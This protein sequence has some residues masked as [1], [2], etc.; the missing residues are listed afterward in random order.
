MNISRWSRVA[1]TAGAA[2][3]GFGL[4]LA[5]AHAPPMRARVLAWALGA[6]E[7]YGIQGRAARL[8]YNLLTLDVRIHDLALAAPGRLSEPFFVA[9]YIEAD[10]GWPTIWGRWSAQA[11]EIRHPR[12]VYRAGLCRWTMAGRKGAGDALGHGTAGRWSTVRSM[13]STIGPSWLTSSSFN[14]LA[15]GYP[16]AASTR[17]GA[18]RTQCG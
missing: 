6:L 3:V 10:L 16:R 15:G 13:A 8:D 2:T 9:D 11:I 12:I 7:A 17:W 1:R 14:R 4:L 5:L 18:A